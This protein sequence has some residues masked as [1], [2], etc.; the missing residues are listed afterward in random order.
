[1]DGMPRRY[2]NPKLEIRSDVQ[3][4]Y[5]FVRLTLP[6]PDGKRRRVAK[7]LAFCDQVSQKEA[8]KLR[9][10]ALEVANAGKLL[11]QAKIKFKDLAKQYKEA[12]MP[13]F[14]VATQK[15]QTSLIDNHIL[16]AFAEH[17]ISDIDKQSVEAWL[18][19]KERDGVAWWT[20]KGLRSVLASMFIAAKDWNLWTGDCPTLGVRVGRK[21]E[22]REKRL[23]T[24]E[25]V[26]RILA[27]VSEDTRLMILTA[28]LL[29]LRISEV[30]GL[31]WGD[32]D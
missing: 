15:W 20:R 7:M 3:R 8:Q 14:S 31:Q 5:Y 28:L 6:G 1:M 19:G 25:Q 9:A 16:P 4:P 21:R 22:V 13:Q 12:R 24:A 17:R 27:A 23:V 18:T 32:I 30:C 10:E 2:Q 26:R 29:G 11:L